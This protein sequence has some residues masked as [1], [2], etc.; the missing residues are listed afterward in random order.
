MPRYL[1]IA[2]YSQTGSKGLLAGGGMSRRD[3][4]AK[5]TASVGGEMLTF[6]FAFGRHD[7]FVMADLPSHAAAS[8]IALSIN[9]SGSARV[10]TVVLLEPEDVEFQEEESISYTV[11]G[12]PVSDV[13]YWPR[14][15]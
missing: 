8:K 12:E 2:D 1:F 9:A 10:E 7:A 11:P 3:V 15:P 5:A 13:N 4:V 14:S 6:N